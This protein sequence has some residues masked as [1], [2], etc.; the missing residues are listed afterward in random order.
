MPLRQSIHRRAYP[1]RASYMALSGL[2]VTA[3]LVQHSVHIAWCAFLVVSALV[4]PHIAFA[5][6]SRHSDRQQAEYE[7]S[8]V[9]ALIVGCWMG[10][11]H[12]SL[13]PCICILIVCA[14][15]RFFA[16]F[17]GHW[18]SAV[19]AL[20]A[21]MGLIAATER[22]VAHW[23]ASLLVQMSLLP[24]IVLHSAF[25]SFSARRMVK[26][27]ARQNL[28]LKRL[29]RIDPLTT[30][31]SRD[32]WW[33]KARASLRQHQTHTEPTSLLLIDIDHFKRINDEYGHV[34]GDEVLKQIGLVIRQSL[35]SHD[36]AGRYG[37]DEFT[38]LCKNT[39]AQ[40]ACSV[41][42]RIRD[43]LVQ[44]RIREHPELRISASIGVAAADQ[45]FKAVSEW[46]KAADS[47][48]YQAKNAGRDQ[49]MD[50]AKAQSPRRNSPATI[51]MSLDSTRVQKP[52]SAITG[53]ALQ[54]AEQDHSA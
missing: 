54:A 24:L 31:Y 51:P 41:A 15:D 38:V 48:L 4:W 30:V 3:C 25:A 2:V 1:L 37:G 27:L 44:I 8:F 42:L 10:L 12:W 14:A 16:G 6:S 7:N 5:H 17:K 43:K 13:L 18:V 40:D 36:I 52:P 9:D 19:I 53:K 29:G 26:T 11:L 34:V 49:V 45:H 50:A 46:I 23:D 47:A 39:C 35:R 21:G 20:L 22:P 28:Q 32:Y 33:K